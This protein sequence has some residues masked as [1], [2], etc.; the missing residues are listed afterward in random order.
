MKTYAE[1]VLFADNVYNLAKAFCEEMIIAES[2]QSHFTN[3][4]EKIRTKNQTPAYLGHMCCA[5]HDFVDANMVMDSAFVKLM[6]REMY[7][8]SN[9]GGSLESM[10]RCESDGDLLN[11]AWSP[12]MATVYIA[13][14]FQ[15]RKVRPICQA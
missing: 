14:M 9:C 10:S 3:L 8:D 4:L 15:C 12:Q 1:S 7:V 13:V 11:A 6:G 2:S 5:S